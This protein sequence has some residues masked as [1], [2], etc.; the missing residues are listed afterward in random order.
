MGLTI[1]YSLSSKVRSPEKAREL[2]AKLH[3]RARDLPF[4]EVGDIVDL[5]GDACDFNKCHNEDR[6]RWLLIQ[7]GQYVDRPA[8]DGSHHSFQVAPT[9]VV[10]FRTLPGAEGEKGTF[11]FL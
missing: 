7:A 3:S 8:R 4:A 11:Y 5:E 6:N 9:H 1:H 2:I 10:A